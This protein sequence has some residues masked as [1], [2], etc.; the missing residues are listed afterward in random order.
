MDETFLDHIKGTSQIVQL[1][2]DVGFTTKLEYN[3]D[4]FLDLNYDLFCEELWYFETPLFRL[5]EKKV[6][7]IIL[8]LLMTASET[9]SVQRQKITVKYCQSEVGLNKPVLAV[10]QHGPDMR[11]VIEGK[12]KCDL[13]R[14]ENISR[15]DWH[16]THAKCK[17]FNGEDYWMYKRQ[18]EDPSKPR[19]I[20]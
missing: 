18:V 1:C 15:W 2:N 12:Q 7:D 16:V 13:K 19:I 8:G 17:N 4:G 6:F 5:E 14:D 20:G 9:F 11:K 3:S 10:M